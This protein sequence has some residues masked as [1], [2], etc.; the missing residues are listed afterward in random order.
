MRKHEPAKDCPDL[1]RGET[2]IGKLPGTHAEEF[3]AFEALLGQQPGES[4]Y[5]AEDRGPL[6]WQSAELWNPRRPGRKFVDVWRL[7]H[8]DAREYTWVGHGMWRHWRRCMD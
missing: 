5:Q 6:T 7:L 3:A 8:P 1:T 2:V 4:A